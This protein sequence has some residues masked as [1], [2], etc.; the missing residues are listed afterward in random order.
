MLER[1][2]EKLADPQLNSPEVKRQASRAAGAAANRKKGTTSKYEMEGNDKARKM[3]GIGV[4][5]GGVAATTARR[6]CIVEWQGD[7]VLGSRGETLVCGARPRR[8]WARRRRRTLNDQE[9]RATN[10]RAKG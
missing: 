7:S 5:G 9:E 4:A 6:G 8:R 3:L 2:E 1:V 10:Q